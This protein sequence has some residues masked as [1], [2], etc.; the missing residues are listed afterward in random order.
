[1]TE[2]R[3]DEQLRS[4]VK[5]WVDNGG[6]KT[7]AAESL[8]IPRVTFTDWLRE[9]ETRFGLK[10]GRMA[11]GTVTEADYEVR[12]LPA[13]GEVKRY[14]LTSIQNNTHLHPAWGAL[15]FYADHLGAEFFVGTLT[16]QK[17]AFGPKAVKRGTSK[18]GDFDSLWY[19]PEALA[20][21]NDKKVELAPGLVW[22]GY[23]NILPTAKR[24]L[25]GFETH[26]G[27]KSNIIPHVKQELESVASMP[28]EGTKFNLTTGTITQ[29]NYIQKKEGQMA[30][31]SHAY[32]GVLVEVDDSGAWWVRH[33]TIGADGA[34]YDVGPA[35]SVPLR[36]TE[37]RIE[38]AEVEGIVWGDI[39]TAEM[40]PWVR[41]LA[42]GGGGMLDALRP[43]YQ[44]AHDIFSMRSR[45]H[46][47]V[48][49]PHV[50]F[51]KY[52][53]GE[54][55]VEDEVAECAAWL[56]E[57]FRPWCKTVV[58]PSNHD[59]HLDR[60]LKEADPREGD[61]PNWRYHTELQLA[62]LRSLEAGANHFNVLEHALRAKGIPE[63]IR[64]LVED[65]SFVLCRDVNGGIEAGLHGDRGVSGAKGTT[66]GLA[67]LGRPVIKAHDHTAA[68]R[69]TVTSVGACSKRFPY[70]HGPSAHSITHAVVYPNGATQ[71]LTMWKDKWRA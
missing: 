12:P 27:R 17:A 11:K 65:E 24:P 7:K 1:M 42:W 10:L 64:F 52:A 53:R 48:K 15:K 71:L 57:A 51:G 55:K 62:V 43:N 6:S 56:A 58:V 23:A 19:A 46:H 59:R 32:G 3:T 54:D 13:P 16:Y 2:P 9:A 20:F 28:D 21:A 38:A 66:A 35:P 4:A 25:N 70:M 29:R 41:R 36:I 50:Q 34:I 60:W 44:V 63:G 45:G 5:A 68:K 30:E 33:L 39:H 37:G 69:G 18:A 26:N 49:D 47:D 67:K 31:A 61:L 22:C 8:G 40:E 14:V